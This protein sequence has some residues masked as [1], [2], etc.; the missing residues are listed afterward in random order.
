MWLLFK[1]N[2]FYNNIL[3]GVSTIIVNILLGKMQQQTAGG[4]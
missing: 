4:H 3:D 2:T 1:L